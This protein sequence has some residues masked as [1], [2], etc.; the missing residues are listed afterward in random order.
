MAAFPQI[1]MRGDR[2]SSYEQWPLDVPAALGNEYTHGIATISSGETLE[3]AA[4]FA[5]GEGRHGAF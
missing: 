1:C 2:M 4:R 5:S 3:G